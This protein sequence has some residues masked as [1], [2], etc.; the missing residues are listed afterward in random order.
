MSAHTA[1]SPTTA[2]NPTWRRPAVPATTAPA[3]ASNNVHANCAS[4]ISNT[5]N[6]PQSSPRRTNTAR[7]T[8]SGSNG[9]LLT[10][11]RAPDTTSP[12]SPTTHNQ[13]S[14]STPTACRAKSGTNGRASNPTTSV[15]GGMSCRCARPVPCHPPS[16][17]RCRAG[18]L[19]QVVELPRTGQR[20]EQQLITCQLR[21]HPEREPHRRWRRL[22]ARGGTHSRPIG[23]R[24]AAGGAS[25]HARVRPLHR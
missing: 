18:Q 3:G 24:P 16:L 21:R 11:R 19:E 2:P 17:P 4:C 8:A 13:S 23:Q 7:R 6:R 14:P 1:V 12:P 15:T 20:Q 25:C 9:I 22:R 10:P 5:Q